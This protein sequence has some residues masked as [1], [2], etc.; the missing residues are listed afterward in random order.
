MLSSGVVYYED[1]DFCLVLSFQS[2]VVV[3][4]E[5]DRLFAVEVCLGNVVQKYLRICY[6]FDRQN[7][8]NPNQ[9]PLFVRYIAAD[10]SCNPAV[11]L[12]KIFIPYFKLMLLI[13]AFISFV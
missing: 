5:L 11:L 9:P 3:V 8:H 6:P 7:F 13:V 10:F 12:Q 4:S 2:G 1:C